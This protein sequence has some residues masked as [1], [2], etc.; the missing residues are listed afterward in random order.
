MR[1]WMIMIVTMALCL[2]ACMNGKAELPQDAIRINGDYG[3]YDSYILPGYPEDL[4]QDPEA[5]KAGSGIYVASADDALVVYENTYTGLG[6]TPRTQCYPTFEAGGLRGSRDGLFCDNG[7]QLITEA[8]IGLILSYGEEYALAITTTRDKTSV[9][10]ISLLDEEWSVT[11]TISL[12]GEGKFIYYVWPSVSHQPSQNLYI[13]S[14]ETFARIDVGAYLDDSIP[15][16]D[17]ERVTEYAVPDYWGNLCPNSL[18]VI[19]DTIYIGD[20]LGLVSVDAD[21]KFR[22][23]PI[24]EKR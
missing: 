18:V 6:E 7:E 4:W 24:E 17:N 21:G 9:H 20:L 19:H 14:T 12:N 22:Y 3:E 13:I 11:H 5:H 1:K 2:S 23:Y 15:Y 16:I 10:S 8:C